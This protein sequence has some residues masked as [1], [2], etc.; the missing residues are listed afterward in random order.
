[1]AHADGDPAAAR[2]A[3]EQE[4]PWR[5]RIE[6]AAAAG[7]GFGRV[8]GDD[9]APKG[10]R[11]PPQGLLLKS[12]ARFF[13]ELRNDSRPPALLGEEALLFSIRLRRPEDGATETR[14]PLIGPTGRKAGF[15]IAVARTHWSFRTSAQPNVPSSEVLS[16]VCVCYLETPPLWTA[17]S[18][19]A[20]HWSAC[21]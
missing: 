18:Y 10:S 15:P 8:K 9:E 6:T 19:L 2:R 14:R 7:A 13:R 1:M 20:P 5:V 17:N 16:Y 11:R 21:S 3:R 4:R 12:P